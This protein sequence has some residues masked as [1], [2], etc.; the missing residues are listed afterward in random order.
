ML[1][2]GEFADVWQGKWNGTTDVAI[3]EFKGNTHI[4][5]SRKTWL[6]QKYSH[7]FFMDRVQHKNGFFNTE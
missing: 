1:G 5:Y 6:F 2:S 7:I 4:R 3:K